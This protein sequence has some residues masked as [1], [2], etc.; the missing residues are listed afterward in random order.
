MNDEL[1]DAQ[2][3]PGTS[4]GR[5]SPRVFEILL[6][7]ERGEI[8]QISDPRLFRVDDPPILGAPGKQ[9]LG[10]IGRPEQG[11]GDLPAEAHRNED[12][13]FQI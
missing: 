12:R 3:S 2:G 8:G 6:C 7:H 11:R 5:R 13:M 10:G 4:P 1:Q 9:S